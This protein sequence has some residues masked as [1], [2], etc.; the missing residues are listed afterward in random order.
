MEPISIGS[1]SVDL[2]MA[3]TQQAAGIEVAKKA[4]GFT[5]ETARTEV[6]QLSSIDP[7]LGQNL[8]LRA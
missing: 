4:M 2:H 6:E 8:D 1:A 5:K 7:N 3:Q